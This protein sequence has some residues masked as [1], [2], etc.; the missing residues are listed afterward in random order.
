M[1]NND[2]QKTLEEKIL[3]L[4]EYSAELE[5]YAKLSDIDIV[6]NKDKFYSIQNDA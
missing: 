5:E 1:N 2:V 4:Q 6:S 3:R